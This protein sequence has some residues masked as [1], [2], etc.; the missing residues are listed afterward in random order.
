MKKLAVVYHEGVA[1]YDFGPGHPF[2]GDRFPRYME[3]L[4]NRGLF[5]EDCRLIEP[6][7]A[8][9]SDLALVHTTD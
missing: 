3:F 6:R 8:E 2:R 4:K 7:T 5:R 1:G 9:D